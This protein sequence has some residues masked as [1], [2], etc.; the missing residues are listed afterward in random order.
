MYRLL[1]DGAQE[2]ILD[3][4][5]A[6]H[7]GPDLRIYRGLTRDEE[8]LLLGAVHTL[9]QPGKLTDEA[10]RKVAADIRSAVS[11]W[12][13]ALGV[14]A[15]ERRA[16]FDRQIAGS[17]EELAQSVEKGAL[18]EAQRSAL[19]DRLTSLITD[20]SARSGR[21]A[22]FMS[23]NLETAKHWGQKGVIGVTVPKALL[24]ELS[25][26]H[27]LY[28]GIENSVELALISRRAAGAAA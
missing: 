13:Q 26:T 27:E 7:P 3:K 17:F 9:V 16:A 25:R 1:T 6:I 18:S 15:P 24:R 28:V 19:A 8:P 23:P 20:A 4:L 11:A 10:R 12:S 21:D 2:A 22:I 14:D 5:D